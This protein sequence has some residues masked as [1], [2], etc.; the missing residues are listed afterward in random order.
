MCCFDNLITS[1]IHPT[2]RVT[3]PSTA[4]PARLSPSSPWNQR[5][6]GERGRQTEKQRRLQAT[7]CYYRENRQGRE[8]ALSVDQFGQN[9]LVK[10]VRE[11]KR[12][13]NKKRSGQ[14]AKDVD[15]L[16]IKRL[17]VKH[18]R[19]ICTYKKINARKSLKLIKITILSSY[20]ISLC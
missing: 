17:W 5:G 18:R 15:E 16:A 12:R 9:C 8:R 20:L 1:R 10:V 19:N 4:R 2:R 3:H 13:K 11:Q 7:L 14:L 6:G